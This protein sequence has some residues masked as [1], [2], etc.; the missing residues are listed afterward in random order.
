[1]KNI[2]ILLVSIIFSFTVM[3]LSSSLILVP[4]QKKDNGYHMGHYKT[5]L[6]PT[7]KKKAYKSPAPNKYKNVKPKGNKHR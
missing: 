5:T 2:R 4:Q 1:M 6:S 7:Y 3:L